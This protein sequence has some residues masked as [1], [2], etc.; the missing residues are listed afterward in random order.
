MKCKGTAG[1]IPVSPTIRLREK[2]K[3]GQTK[4]RLSVRRYP[5]G[6]LANRGATRRRNSCEIRADC[7]RH[8]PRPPGRQ[9]RR[10]GQSFEHPSRRVDADPLARHAGEDERHSPPMRGRPAGLSRPVGS[11]HARAGGPRRRASASWPW[12]S[13]SA[14]ACARRRASWPRRSDCITR[15]RSCAAILREAEQAV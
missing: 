5:A 1:S 14:S 3:P 11:R 9:R 10:R 4:R 15:R 13:A 7:S 8:V 12:M 6:I 2:S